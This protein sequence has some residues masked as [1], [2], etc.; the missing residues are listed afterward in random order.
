MNKENMQWIE[1]EKWWNSLAHPWEEPAAKTAAWQAWQFA[2]YRVASKICY[3][4]GI[5][6]RCQG[7]NGAMRA[8]SEVVNP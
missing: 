3:M 1:F 4:K 5:D 7:H 6:E 2:N 8:I